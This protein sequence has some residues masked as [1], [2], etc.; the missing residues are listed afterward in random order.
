MTYKSRYYFEPNKSFYNHY[1]YLLENPIFKWKNLGTNFHAFKM[2]GILRP[3]LFWL[4]SIYL[5]IYLYIYLFIY[6]FIY[7]II[8]LFIYLFIY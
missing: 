6:L 5:F 7:L 4:F 8:Y 3:R 1:Y 2:A